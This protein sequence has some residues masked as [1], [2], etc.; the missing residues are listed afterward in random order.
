MIGQ[1][2]LPYVTA[3]H[4]CE[5]SEWFTPEDY[6]EPARIVLGGHIDLD[7]ASCPVANT[8]IGAERIYTIQEDGL[9]PRR[10][11]RGR[12]FLNPPNPPRPWWE[13]LG[14]ELSSG[15]VTQAIYL[16][17]SKEP[18]SQSQLWDS[19]SILS[20]IVCIPKRRIQF[21]CTSEDALAALKKKVANR[22]AREECSWTRAELRRAEELEGKPGT[23]V[24]GEQPPHASAIVGLGVDRDLFAAQFESKGDIVVRYR[25]AS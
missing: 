7:P 14:V 8:V 21:L 15:N 20:Y 22:I 4:S 9:D 5:S 3:A 24:I 12:V 6:A 1:A 19:P 17:Y 13:R 23:L 16:S 11:W 25:R 10:E 18:L 2:S